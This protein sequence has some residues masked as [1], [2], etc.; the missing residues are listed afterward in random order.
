MS[1]NFNNFIFC[2]KNNTKLRKNK[3]LKGK[4]IEKQFYNSENKTMILIEIL[5][6]KKHKK[7]LAT[8]S[9]L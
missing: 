1:N 2:C 6:T 4:K 7:K 9:R 3:F 8:F 5:K